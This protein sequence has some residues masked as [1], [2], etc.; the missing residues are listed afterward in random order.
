[1]PPSFRT[2]H[3]PHTVVKRRW[4]KVLVY[5]PKFTFTSEFSLAET[6]SAMGMPL[7]FGDEADFSGINGKRDLFISAVL[8]KAFV[9]VNESGTEAAAATAVVMRLKSRGSSPRRSPPVF[10]ADHLFMF[11]IRDRRTG[12][13]LFMGRITNPRAGRAQ[14]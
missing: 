10:R 5:L 4:R 3:P 1:M 9:E 8:H 2:S 13:I 7:A 6:L 11:M 12:T 14:S